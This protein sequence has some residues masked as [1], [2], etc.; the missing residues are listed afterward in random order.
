MTQTIKLTV[1]DI[2]YTNGLSETTV[3]N[4]REWAGRLRRKGYKKSILTKK[5][6]ANITITIKNKSK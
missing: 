4:K 3:M 6:L 5:E 2:L 1:V